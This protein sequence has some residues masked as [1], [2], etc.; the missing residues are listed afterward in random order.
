MEAG[1][2]ALLGKT[3]TLM[4]SL[5]LLWI[6]TSGFELNLWDEL[7][8]EKTL[9]DLI[10]LHPAWDRLL[11]DH[12]L[13]QAGSLGLLIKDNQ[14]Y[15]L[16]KLGKAVQSYRYEGLEALYKELV[17]HWSPV[18]AD[19]PQ[20]ITG[21]AD[22]KSFASEMEEEL[23]AKAS[24][25]SEPFVWPFLVKK[26]NDSKWRRILD[27]GCGEGLYLQ[28]LMEFSPS[29][30]GIG[31]EINPEVALRARTNCA[32]Y[33]DR[34]KIICADALDFQLD[35]GTFDV[36]LLNNNIYYFNP[37]QRITLLY[38][39]KKVLN[40]GGQIGIL[41]AL[42]G[43]NDQ[44]ELFSTQMPRHLM[45]FFL[46]CHRGFRGLPTEAEIRELL[47][48]T[49]YIDLEVIP[50]PFGMSHFFFASSV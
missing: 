39:I 28:K 12:W 23:I 3:I 48:L 40:P 24:L 14:S 25:A 50:L 1:M 42:R 15:K 17:K 34:L 47:T 26:F 30:Q 4:E 38:N 27:I 7:K 19:L 11:L 36:S 8:E 21:D 43:T 16:S 29:L 10:T 6:L 20:L 44:L 33:N 45:S 41:T 18:F 37:D 46:A 9:D 22:K 32:A 2:L 49:G 31:I 35:I 5:G 13:E